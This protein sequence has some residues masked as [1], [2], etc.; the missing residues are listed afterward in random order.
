MEQTMEQTMARLG[1]SLEE[2]VEALYSEALE[3]DPGRTDWDEQRGAV[4]ALEGQ[5]RESVLPD[6]AELGDSLADEERDEVAGSV[7]AVGGRLAAV[8]LASGKWREGTELIAEMA[9]LAAGDQVAELRAAE[10]DPDSYLTYL[11]GRFLVM[12]ERSESARKAF[13][14][15][16]AG[17]QEKALVSAARGART[18]SKPLTSAPTLF[19]WNGFGLGL[20]G[21]RDRHSGTHVTTHCLSALWIPVLPLAAYRVIDHGD[22]S[23]GFLAREPLSQLAVWYRRAILAAVVVAVIGF[24]LSSYL[25][26]PERL[27]GKAFNEARQAEQAGDID[28]AIAG[29]QGV[30]DEHGHDVHGVV[31]R[32]TGVALTGLYLSRI[33][34]PV[35]HRSV[36]HITRVLRR[37]D[38]MPREAR[39]AAVEY[40]VID[41]VQSWSAAIG[42]G[43]PQA[44]QANLTLL[45]ATIALIDGGGV[46]AAPLVAARKRARL[47]LAASLESEWPLEALDQYMDEA[48]RDEDALRAAGRVVEALGER[49][50]L[51]R[52]AAPNVKSWLEG[53]S[54][55]EDLAS[56]RTAVAA[57]MA[58]AQAVLEDAERKQLLGSPRPGEPGDAGDAGESRRPA[59][60]E[61]LT[62]YL[63][64]SPDDQEIAVAVAEAR[65]SAN[66]IPGALSVL[67]GFGGAGWLIPPGQQLLATL[68]MEA[69][70]LVEADAILGRIV[71]FRLPRMQ[72]ASQAYMTTARSI[73]QR[74]IDEVNAGRLPP[75]LE[76][77]LLGKDESEQQ[78][79]FGE[80]LGETLQNHPR[81]TPLRQAYVAHSSVVPLTLTLGTV[82]LRR[83]N[84]ATGDA[85][86]G[87]LDEAEQVFLAIR[88]DAEGVPSY[89]LGL[90]QVYHR[91]GRVEE[92]EAEFRH[93]LDLGQ[94]ELALEV[95]GAYRELGLATRAKEI[96]ETVWDSQQAPYHQAA[97]NMLGIMAR[98]PDEAETW[99]KRADQSAPGV[100]MSLRQ[101]E[102]QRFAREGE[103]ADADRAMAEVSAFYARDAAHSSV[104]ANNAA[105]AYLARFQ[106]T[107]D[108]KHVLAACQNFDQGLRLEP[109]SAV[110]VRNASGCYK[111][112]GLLEVLEPWLDAS[113]VARSANEMQGIL[114]LLIS[115]SLRQRAVTGMRKSPALRR[116]IIL[117]ERYMVLAPRNP[118]GYQQAASWYELMED[119]AKLTTVRD[120]VA[121]QGD[122]DTAEQDDQRAR[123]LAGEHDE[124]MIAD[125]DQELVTAR[126]MLEKTPARGA[127]RA[128]AEVMV[129]GLLESRGKLRNQPEDIARAVEGY[130]RAARAW[131]ELGI[132][133]ALAR[134]LVR[135]AI[136]KAAGQSPPLTA[137]WNE[138]HRVHGVSV[139]LHRATAG[140]HGASI[141][142]SLREQ[143]EV[144]EA[145]GL[146]RASAANLPGL[147][148]WVLGR[149]AGDA[150][151]ETAGAG[152][153]E[154]PGKRLVV[155]MSAS[156]EPGDADTTAMVQIMK[157][158]AGK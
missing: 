102:A 87:L 71:A 132:E 108:K 150:E 94:P 64:K 24:S 22:D 33:P 9:A 34:E 126:G 56:Q 144:A 124:S 106:Y 122:F 62:A 119:V 96:A 53:S 13:D 104:A 128:A 91:L 98:D 74:L 142:A 133:Y 158:G 127:V 153:F 135:L 55:Y 88:Q 19:R 145:V 46:A 12:N 60:L 11:H 134:A 38:Q 81:L 85:R 67:T 120:A 44:A 4:D 113:A 76:A 101:L 89:H 152:W 86:Q 157:A 90:A 5:F 83:A 156:L 136:M 140:E 117:L 82:K 73:E 151:L 79:I 155:E 72:R 26:D 36:D 154:R 14:Q 93:V 59:S 149:V 39:D 141:V 95:V 16:I 7:A 32:D 103:M 115:S 29:Y 75:G 54:K 10:R 130:R 114:S 147:F 2:I 49:H 80:W 112:L 78:A 97:A 20:Y 47:G 111:T 17:C 31:I 123:F 28:R 42:H 30:L 148:D 52:S 107:G 25:G 99:F 1:E 41:R 131:P 48:A 105:V 125:L 69:G 84:S 92:G 8:L 121:R 21:D 6:L 143:P 110:M 35:D 70:Q 3:P 50:S 137:L 45:D 43:S 146:S 65:A 15:V 18:R 139:F 23:Y 138:E 100:R 61:A 63:A 116:S 40:V 77:R 118:F 37:V 57:R 27:A 66:D 58:A 129:A 51:L 109:D 68:Y